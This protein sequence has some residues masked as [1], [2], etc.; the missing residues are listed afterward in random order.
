MSCKNCM[1]RELGCHSIC[2]EYLEFRKIKELEYKARLDKKAT[3]LVLSEKEY[4]QRYN[5]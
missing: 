5:K 2:S 3:Y 4:F 1:N